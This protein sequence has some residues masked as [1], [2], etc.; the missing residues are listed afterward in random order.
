MANIEEKVEALVKPKIEELGYNLYD[1]EYAKEGK[2]YFLRIYIENE[3]GI[4]LE[5]C[6]KVTGEI[7]DILDKADYVKNE[8]FLEVSSTGI[9]KILRKDKHLE[10][11]I[12]EEIEVR[13]FKPI[14]KE[15]ILS[16]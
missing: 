5:D 6:E 2:D 15:K 12:G 9:E 16:R 3:K 14:D 7:N 1:V 10:S 8:Y 13:L 4:S 11:A